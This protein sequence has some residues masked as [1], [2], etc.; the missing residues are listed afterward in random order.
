MK[1][2]EVAAEVKDDVSDGVKPALVCPEVALKEL[3]LVQKLEFLLEM[4]VRC[5]LSLVI[6]LQN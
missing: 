6:L 5:S 4:L 3:K 2:G 1:H